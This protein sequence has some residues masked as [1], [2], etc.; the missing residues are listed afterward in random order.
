MFLFAK[1][2]EQTLKLD[3]RRKSEKVFKTDNFISFS[4]QKNQQRIKIKNLLILELLSLKKAFFKYEKSSTKAKTYE[5]TQIRGL[6][7]SYFLYNFFKNTVGL[8][9]NVQSPE[10]DPFCFDFFKNYANFKDVKPFIV[11][12]LSSKL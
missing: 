12:A 5:V 11:S 10:V 1:K 7:S 9:K 6:L 3:R 8:I 4:V 2:Y